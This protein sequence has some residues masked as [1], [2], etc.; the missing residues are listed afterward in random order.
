MTDP[1][2][3]ILRE[4]ATLPEDRLVNVLNTIR[5][6]KFSLDMDEK[7]IEARF[8]KSWKHV[9]A[10]TKKLNITQ[11]DIEAEI[12]AVPSRLCHACVT[13]ICPKRRKH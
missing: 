3:T 13:V 5:F 1:E 9:R 2:Q 8:E 10:R 11:E 12:R 4:I 6:L 7:A